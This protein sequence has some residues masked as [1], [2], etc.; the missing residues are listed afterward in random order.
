MTRSEFKTL[1][2]NPKLHE[3]LKNYCNDNGLKLNAW[4][5]KILEKTIKDREE[6]K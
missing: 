1:K 2:I 5:E 3:K 4:V 6:I